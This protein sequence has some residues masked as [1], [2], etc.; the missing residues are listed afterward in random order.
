MN[1]E[2]ESRLQEQ[3][4]A[5]DIALKRLEMQI[6]HI[7]SGKRQTA[8]ISDNDVPFAHAVNQ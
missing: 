7:P 8:S 5:F 3:R 4:V 1:V 6:Q 2:I